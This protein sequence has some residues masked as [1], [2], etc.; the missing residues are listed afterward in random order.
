LSGAARWLT[1]ILQPRRMSIFTI[2]ERRS[3]PGP[4]ESPQRCRSHLAQLCQRFAP[5]SCA[6]GWG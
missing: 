3:L 1:Q 4:A 5:F 2:R 6:S